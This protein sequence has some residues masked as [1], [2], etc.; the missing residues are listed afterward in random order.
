MEE[1]KVPSS[2]AGS[3]D[4]LLP[5]LI[6]HQVNQTMNMTEKIMHTWTFIPIPVAN[7]LTILKQI[8]IIFRDAAVSTNQT[9]QEMFLSR[10]YAIQYYIHNLTYSYLY[11][12]PPILSYYHFC[13]DTDTKYIL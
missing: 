11:I 5:I 12:C 8:I 13:L 6:G 9:L 4:A 2:M 1:G 3:Q 7:G 10:A